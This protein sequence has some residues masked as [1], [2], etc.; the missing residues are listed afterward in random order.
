MTRRRKQRV[1]K[2]LLRKLRDA[3]AVLARKT[4]D[5]VRQALEIG[6]PT[7][8]RWRNRAPTRWRWSGG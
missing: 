6:E 5:E 7:F 4:I 3:Q 2:R 8:R 1:P